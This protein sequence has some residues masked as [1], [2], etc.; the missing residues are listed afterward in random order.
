MHGAFPPPF[1]AGSAAVPSKTS[2][3]AAASLL[4]GVL[5]FLCFAGFGGALA[6]ALGWIA[7]GEIER[8]EGR[9]SGKGLASAGIALGIA[10]L[11]VCVVAIGVLVALAVRPDPPRAFSAPTVPP[12]I[13]PAPVSPGPN[14]PSARGAPTPPL[15][16]SELPALPSAIG[17]VAI[18]DAD[19]TGNGLEPLLRQQ[20]LETQKSGEKVLLWTVAPACQPCTAVGR[21]L[22]DS[23]MQR[24]LGKIR[25]VRADVSA[26]APELDR[27][28]VPRDT[29]PGFTLFDDRARPLDHIHGGEW[30]DDI[31]ANIAPILEKFVRRTLTVRRYPW[32]RS[33]RSDEMPL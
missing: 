29:V 10:N 1:D 5:S 11:V 32:L 15:A 25:L 9:L 18:I 6:I 3:T 2:G 30:D 17:S 12:R 31:P 13:A 20:L 24:A 14:P 23:R 8:S 4:T 28:G 22:P 26:L 16:D 33:L 27:L 7:H 19:S 21:A